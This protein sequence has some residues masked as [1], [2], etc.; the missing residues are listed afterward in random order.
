MEDHGNIYGPKIKPLIV[1]KE[2]G[3]DIDD[4]L[5]LFI[6]ENVLKNWNNYKKNFLK[7]GVKL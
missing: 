1:S 6:S 5:D 7:K 4:V 3:I 2:E